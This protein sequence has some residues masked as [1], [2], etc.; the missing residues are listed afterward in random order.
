H[1]QQS[2]DGGARRAC[3]GSYWLGLLLQRVSTPAVVRKCQYRSRFQPTVHP[4]ADLPGQARGGM[5]ARAEML[6]GKLPALVRVPAQ[7]SPS[8][9][10]ALQFRR[11]WWLENLLYVRRPLASVR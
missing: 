3:R 7:W 8:C 6:Y 2:L 10:A 4:A 9:T 1:R 11:Y 5:S